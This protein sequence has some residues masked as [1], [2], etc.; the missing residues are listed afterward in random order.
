M[1]SKSMVSSAVPRVVFVVLSYNQQKYIRA[2]VQ[3]ALR[4]DYEPLT[5]VFS[6]D[7]STD[8][9][10]HVI[11]E[12]VS[13]YAGPHQ[14]IIKACD[15]NLGINGHV[16]AVMSEIDADFFVAAAGDDISPPERTRKFVEAWKRGS[17]GVYSNA[18]IIDENGEHG[19]LLADRS[20]E[21][22][23]DWK[24][25][26]RMGSHGSW[27]CAYAW[28]RKVFDIFDGVPL[29]VIGEDAAIPFRCALLGRITYLQQPLV[30]YRSHGQNLS[31]WSK[32]KVS[33]KK[34]LRELSLEY[35]SA[36]QVH[37]ENWIKDV[38]VAC[39]QN[40]ITVEE[41]EWA[42]I[43]LKDHIYLKRE[44][45]KMMSSGV[46]HLLIHFSVILFKA[47]TAHQPVYWIRHS[48]SIILQYRFPKIRHFLLKLTRRRLHV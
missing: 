20:Y 35:L 25:M 48:L 32:I 8:E 29:N 47:C 39:K 34:E 21:G 43:I 38:Q 2:A 28:D 15:T 41:S 23:A 6:D 11:R 9:T 7:C 12:E 13:K 24:D 42:K 1:K 37:Y 27:G 45:I 22:F 40:L 10:Q 30:F 36:L 31:F 26:V 18:E 5:I 17:I 46:C 14:I 4:Q 16:N 3:G 44:Q 19:E 33:D